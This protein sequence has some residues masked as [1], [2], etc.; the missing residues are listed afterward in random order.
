M[1][2]V[3]IIKIEDLPRDQ[4]KFLMQDIRKECRNPCKIL[5]LI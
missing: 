3:P 2:E 5:K 1:L 4:N